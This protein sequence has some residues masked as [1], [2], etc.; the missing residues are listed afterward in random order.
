MAKR[1]LQANLNH[2]T[3]AQDLCYQNTV[4]WSIDLV[5][6]AEP[7]FVP[8]SPNWLGDED[9]LV[10]I[11]NADGTGSLSFSLLGRGQGYVAATWGEI[12]VVGAYCSPNAN[13]PEFDELMDN[14]E[15]VIRPVRHRPIIVA[16]DLNA[17]SDAWGSP[18]TNERGRALVEWAHL[19]HLD[20]LNQ[21]REYTCVRHNGASIVDVTFGNPA[22]ARRIREWQVLGGEET[23]SDH[24]FIRFDVSDP[25]MG[26]LHLP[27]RGTARGGTGPP[28][29]VRRKL[30]KDLLTAAAIVK[31][32]TGGVA[33]P[34]TPDEGAEKLREALTEIC[35]TAMP[36]SRPAP[37]RK[38]A[39]YRWTPELAALREECNAARR[40]LTGAAEEEE[41]P[42]RWR[43]RRWPTLYERS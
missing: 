33:N 1:L 12:V 43:T 41:I 37:D 17:K 30:D 19:L 29:W 6:A 21:G 15:N 26:R 24:R 20:T 7:Y 27:Q 31:A 13:L 38:T 34:A 36:R 14:I 18:V 28:R 3:A 5:I 23:L 11:F 25:S 40:R 22:A 9:G 10:A 16:G 42:R 4:E 2:S 39:A 32:W 8:D 35:D